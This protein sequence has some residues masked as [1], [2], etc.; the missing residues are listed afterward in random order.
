[1]IRFVM[2]WAVTGALVPLA[3]IVIAQLQRGVF[4]WP[5]LAVAFWPSS[6]I[7]IGTYEREFTF[8]GI[9]AVVISIA[10]NVLLYSAIGAVLWLLFARFF[11]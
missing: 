9:F 3:I 7:L 2:Y 11:K 4:R 10:I 1:M 8:F 6:I 5:E